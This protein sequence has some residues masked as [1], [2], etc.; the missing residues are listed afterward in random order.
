MTRGKGD[1]LARVKQVKPTKAEM[2]G[3]ES[4]DGVIGECYYTAGKYAVE[5]K[6]AIL[7]H[8]TCRLND[9][10]SFRYGH[11]WV[12]LNSGKV[13]DGTANRFFD[14]QDY[15]EKLEAIS[16][17]EYGWEEM[18]KMLL[19]TENW[20]CWHETEGVTVMH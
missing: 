17:I 4:G 2:K 7:V 12:L 3:I 13:Y 20:G 15:Y 9:K 14:Q 8:G 5:H 11:G 10:A 18:C 19:K 1:R 6:D 16:E